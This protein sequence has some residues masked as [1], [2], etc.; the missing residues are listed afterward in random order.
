MLLDMG[1]FSSLP[2]QI[3]DSVTPAAQAHAPGI[4][5]ANSSLLAPE[6]DAE[7]CCVEPFGHLPY[8]RHGAPKPAPAKQC[9]EPGDRCPH[10]RRL[11]TARQVPAQSL[12][13]AT[14]DDQDKYR[15]D[16][17]AC[18]NAAY[19]GRASF[20]GLDGNRWHSLRRVLVEI[21]QMRYRPIFRGR[22]AMASAGFVLSAFASIMT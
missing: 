2:F 19:V 8:S 7:L 1:I 21:R 14:I 5:P 16:V 13:R 6:M 22:Q 9:A 11:A 18:S 12:A 20:V 4:L 10:G 17:F 15:P 3:N